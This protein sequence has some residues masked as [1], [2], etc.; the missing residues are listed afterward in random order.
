M[1]SHAILE[2]LKE[3]LAGANVDV[4][5]EPMGGGPGG[6]CDIKGRKIFFIDTDSSINEAIKS[7]A[8]AVSELVDIESIYLKPQIREIITDT[9]RL[10]HKTADKKNP[11][12]F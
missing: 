9:A 12:L 10:S 11:G 7:A 2:E 1:D 3:L 8:L 6:L 5:A 4:R